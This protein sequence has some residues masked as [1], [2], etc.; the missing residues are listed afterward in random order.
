MRKKSVICIL[1]LTT[2][3]LVGT[4]FRARATAAWKVFFNGAP[5]EMKVVQT[6]QG[7]LVAV[8][9]H[10]PPKGQE[11]SYYIRVR[12]SVDG[13]KIEIDRI[14]RKNVVRDV[15]DCPTCTGSGDCQEC[16]P[17]GSKMNT[18]GLPCLLCNATGECWMCTGSGKCYVCGGSVEGCPNCRL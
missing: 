17:P 8:G 13:D 5:S 7:P 12:R 18:A 4:D 2:C 6:E 10:L 15:G 3:L 14:L 9:F 1:I 11:Q 16:Y